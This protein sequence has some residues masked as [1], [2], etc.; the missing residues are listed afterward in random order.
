LKF[1]ITR[2]RAART[3]TDIALTP[4]SDAEDMTLDLLTSTTGANAAVAH[5][6][7]I[8]ALTGTARVA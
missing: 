2:D 4:V 8:A 3:Y 7:K 6:R 1:V 5:L